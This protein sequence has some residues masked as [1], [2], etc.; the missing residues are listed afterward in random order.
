MCLW[1]LHV[2]CTGCKACGHEGGMKSRIA[3]HSK[4]SG[5]CTG[6]GCDSGCVPRQWQQCECNFHRRA[7]ERLLNRVVR[8]AVQTPGF[9]NS[10]R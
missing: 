5:G 4:R 7:G 2:Q 8:R 3:Q 1:C 9:M 10:C 6:C